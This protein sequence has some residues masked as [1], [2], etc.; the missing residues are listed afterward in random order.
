[1]LR[2]I[3]L[4]VIF[5][6]LLY[7]PI[8]YYRYSNNYVEKFISKIK[9]P[10]IN[11]K[12][13]VFIGGLH[14]SGTSILSQILGSSNKI[15]R[16]TDTNKYEDEGQHIQTVYENGMEHGGVGKF[17]F[18]KNYHYTENSNLINEFNKST[19]ITQ[20]EKFW[21]KNK[22]IYLEKSPVNLIH[23]RFLQ[24]MFPNSYFIIII[25]NPIV[26]SYATMKW[27]DQSLEQYLKHWILGYNIFKK[28]SKYLKNFIIIK[29][30]DLCDNPHKEI[31]K[32]EKMLNEE[33]NI[34]SSQLDRLK[35]SNYKYLKPISPDLIHKYEKDVS[36]FNYTLIT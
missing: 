14:R 32:I 18:D 19:L 22:Y 28:D 25:R 23:T 4:I 5:I 13:Y 17:C 35:N 36:K 16:H 11:K 9:V 1:M 27:K 3:F 2:V 21:N 7:Y 29:Y 30:E 12:K 8:I 15:S 20:W 10:A 6:L 26:V 34:D 33:L 24:R 31:F